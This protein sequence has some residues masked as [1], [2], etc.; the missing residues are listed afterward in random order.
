MRSGLHPDADLCPY[1]LPSEDCGWLSTSALV[2]SM[3]T[4]RMRIGA[5]N[6]TGLEAPEVHGSAGHRHRC[7]LLARST[8]ACPL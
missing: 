7:A 6:F 4:N 1:L 3:R 5:A 8:P 2:S